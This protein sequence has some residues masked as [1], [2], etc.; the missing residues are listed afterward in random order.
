LEAMELT[1]SRSIVSSSDSM[2][3]IGVLLGCL[4]SIE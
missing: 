1:A 2:K 3:S 4:W